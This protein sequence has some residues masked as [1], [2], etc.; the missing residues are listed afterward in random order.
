M[1]LLVEAIEMVIWWGWCVPMQSDRNVVSI[2]S[3]RMDVMPLFV[4]SSASAGEYTG[5][6]IADAHTAK[7][8]P[9]A[10]FQLKSINLR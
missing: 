1:S 2:S 7:I 6:S 9:Q 10:A 3:A 8:I 4:V 5:A